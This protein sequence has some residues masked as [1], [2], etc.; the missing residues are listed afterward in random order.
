M[1]QDTFIIFDGDSFT[2]GLH[3]DPVVNRPSHTVK[4]LGRPVDWV[5]V[6]LS[7]ESIATRLENF[8]KNIAA[9]FNR[10]AKRN[11]VSF[12]IGGNDL[13]ALN[14]QL[15][16]TWR[17]ITEYC[18]KARGLG[19]SIALGTLPPH[20]VHPNRTPT[21]AQYANMEA[22]SVHIR[23]SAGVHCD[24][25]VDYARHP[26]VGPMASVTDKT[27]YVDQVHPTALGHS[28]FAEL[29]A[30]ALNRLIA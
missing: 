9:N 13:V 14:R 29:E 26:V 10:K 16:P 1:A 28:H 15:E 6:A 18:A 2:S 27:L 11:I 5:N 4:L 17:A 22:L 24:A 25:V 23:G 7:G 20:G 12:L 8:D 3:V 19:F 21:P 30:E